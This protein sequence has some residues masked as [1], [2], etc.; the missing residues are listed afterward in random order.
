MIRNRKGQTL[1]QIKRSLRQ[2]TAA[3]RIQ[4]KRERRLR[5]RRQKAKEIS[6]KFE[7]PL[8]QH[9]MQRMREGRDQAIELAINKPGTVL[10]GVQ[11]VGLFD[12]KNLREGFNQQT[13]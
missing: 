2:S 6:G 4:G 12:G 8:T 7:R 10:T 1:P 11:S 5:A 9:Q 13:H 3:I